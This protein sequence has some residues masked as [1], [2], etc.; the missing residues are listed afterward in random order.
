MRHR[1]L[2]EE[3]KLLSMQPQTTFTR[4][5]QRQQAH[6]EAVAMALFPALAWG[7]AALD[8][9]IT[10]RGADGD[11]YVSAVT[12]VQVVPFQVPK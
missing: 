6:S 11:V 5:H 4:L 7:T 10:A 3:E 1:L 8:S 2:D 12:W 9:E